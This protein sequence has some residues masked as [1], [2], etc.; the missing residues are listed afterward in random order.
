MPRV[1]TNPR[2][3]DFVE[4]LEANNLSADT[5]ITDP[6]GRRS[7]IGTPLQIQRGSLDSH[8]L[9]FNSLFSYYDASANSVRHATYVSFNR[10]FN[11][12]LDFPRELY[13]RQIDR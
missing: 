6:L 4:S 5:N 11:R 1:N 7:L 3:I 9:G 10:R 8:F 12:G 13:V 2:D